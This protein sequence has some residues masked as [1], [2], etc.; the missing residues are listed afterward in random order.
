[1]HSQKQTMLTRKNMILTIAALAA[2]GFKII[3]PAHAQSPYEN[4]S[5]AQESVS[6]PDTKLRLFIQA[7]D[8][9]DHVQDQYRRAAENPD[10]AAAESLQRAMGEEIVRTIEAYGITVDEYNTILAEIQ[11]TDSDTAQRYGEMIR[12]E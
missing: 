12:T 4:R 8:A 2:L 6:V 3:A 5:K 9:V 11:N 10:G 7:Q 1:M